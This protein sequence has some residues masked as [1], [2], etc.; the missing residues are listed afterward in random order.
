MTPEAFSQALGKCGIQQGAR[1][2]A[3]VSGGADSLCLL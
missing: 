1:V 2:L 3:A